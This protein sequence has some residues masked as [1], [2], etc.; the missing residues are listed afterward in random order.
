MYRILINMSSVFT[1]LIHVAF[2]KLSFYIK[3]GMCSKED[4]FNI[5]TLRKEMNYS[6]V[7]NSG[8]QELSWYG[9]TE[10]DSGMFFQ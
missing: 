9:Q 6:M 8:S 10:Q 1:S 2:L 7:I 4:D 3:H 5:Q